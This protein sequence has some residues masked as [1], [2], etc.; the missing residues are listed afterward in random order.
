M[1]NEE[2]LRDYLKRATTDLR[3]AHQQISELRERHH[4]PIAIVGMACR[5][6]GGVSSPEGL[7]RLVVDG[8]DAISG[9]PTDRG[10]DLEA[11]YDPEPN[12][13]GTSYVCEGGFLNDCAEFDAGLFGISPR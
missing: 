9:L 7:W 2:K 3:H 1:S 10:W 4:E 8:T 6:P 13:P 5:F 11:L 12:T